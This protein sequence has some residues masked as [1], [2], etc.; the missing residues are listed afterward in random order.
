MHQVF[1]L[2]GAEEYKAWTRESMSHHILLVCLCAETPRACNT[3]K[4]NHSLSSQSWFVGLFYVLAEQP[5]LPFIQ[6]RSNTDKK[7]DSARY[8]CRKIDIW[9][10]FSPSSPP[11]KCQRQQR[12]W[13]FH[14]SS[15]TWW[16]QGQGMRW[17]REALRSLGRCLRYHKLR[18]QFQSW[19]LWLL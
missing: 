2:I 19:I 11:S 10:G 18:W 16:A 13:S 12:G 17:M 15:I 9:W 1:I 7:Q 5:L 6:R 4:W 3:F 14:S 8:F